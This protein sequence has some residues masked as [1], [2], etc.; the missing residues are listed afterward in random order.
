MPT[1]FNDIPFWEIMIRLTA[2]MILSGLVGLERET[3]EKPAGVRTYAL[4][5][6]GAAS[7]MLFSLF[8][9]ERWA[10]AGGVTLDLIRAVSGVVGGVGFL[11][12]GAI[13]HGQGNV[14]GLTTAAGI[15]VVAAVGLACGAGAYV[16]AA[17]TVGLA[18]VILLLL[19]LLKC[20]FTPGQDDCEQEQ[21]SDGAK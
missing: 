5:G 10:G 13:I 7:F 2:A 3:R 11:G 20:R 4:V 1:G 9:V 14:K 15:W 19:H 21:S 17:T 12:A 6:L 8:I 16:I 18:Y